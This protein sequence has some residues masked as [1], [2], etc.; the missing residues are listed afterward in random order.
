MAMKRMLGFF[1][2]GKVAPVQQSGRNARESKTGKAVRFK[3]DIIG[4]IGGSASVKDIRT[5]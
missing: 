4:A 2:A 1:E 3:L 5:G